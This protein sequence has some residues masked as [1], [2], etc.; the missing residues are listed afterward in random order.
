MDPEGE[1]GG[2]PYCFP[3][4]IVAEDIDVAE[5]LGHVGGTIISMRK[6]NLDGPSYSHSPD[7]PAVSC[8][9]KVRLACILSLKT[10]HKLF[11]N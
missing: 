2:T 4:N 8:F 9:H 10:S 7:V 11:V 1:S 5:L 6:P 3:V